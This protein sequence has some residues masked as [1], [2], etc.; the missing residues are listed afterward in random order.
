M[1][2]DRKA[3][4]GRGEAVGHALAASCFAVIVAVVVLV[5]PFGVNVV[6]EFVAMAAGV[7]T[8]VVALAVSPFMLVLARRAGHLTYCCAH[9]IAGAS[10]GVLL[11]GLIRPLEKYYSYPITVPIA[12]SLGAWLYIVLFHPGKNGWLGTGPWA[13]VRKGALSVVGLAALHATG[14]LGG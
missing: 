7:V 13:A 11:F 8:A 12:A 4:S 2:D 9:L 14:G 5:V 1:T 6:G 10:G 3:V